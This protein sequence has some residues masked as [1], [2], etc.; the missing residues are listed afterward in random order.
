MEAQEEYSQAVAY[1]Q[2]VYVLYGAYKKA[3]IQAYLRSGSCFE[4]LGDNPAA[5]KTYQ[6]FLA[7]DFSAGSA[8]AAYARQR[9]AALSG[10][11]PQ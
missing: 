8:A 9:I 3:V 4:K 2:R 1:Y 7:S 10:G 6:E 5:L 11:A